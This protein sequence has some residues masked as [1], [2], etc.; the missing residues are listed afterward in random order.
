MALYYR[1]S[2]TL[3]HQNKQIANIKMQ[4]LHDKI[5]SREWRCGRGRERV[6]SPSVKYFEIVTDTDMLISGSVG[7]GGS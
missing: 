5:L 7:S 1:G 4:F 3:N 2:R 6:A